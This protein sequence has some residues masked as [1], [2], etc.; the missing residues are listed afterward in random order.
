MKILVLTPGIY[1]D[2]HSGLPKLV[3][4]LA[5]ECARLGHGITILTRQYD[6]SHPQEEKRDGM[7]FL[8]I[9]IAHYG[10]AWH[11]LWPI[12]TAV[13]SWHGQRRLWRQNGAFELVWIHNPWWVS[14]GYPKRFWPAARVVYD[15]HS[16]ATSELVENHGNSLKTRLMGGLYDRLMTR[17][18]SRADKIIV[19]SQ[20]NRRKCLG[21]LGGKSRGV[22]LIPG[23][24]DPEL[25]HPADPSGKK[26]L[27]EEFGLPADKVVFV[28]AR[29]LRPRTGVDKLVEAASLL[30]QRGI[31]FY[32]VIIGNGV[33][34]NRIGELIRE[35][36]LGSH[37]KLVS[38][39]SESELADTYRAADVFVL[40]TQGAE[41][42]GLAT[43]EALSSGLV[44]LGTNNSATP[45]ILNRFNP[46]WLIEGCDAESIAS[47]MENY[48]GY[49]EKFSL[50]VETIRQRALE[51]YSWS[52]SA[53][54]FMEA[55][56]G[57]A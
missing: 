51:H 54:L 42:F 3:F 22:H 28:T 11:P 55:V 44:V 53:K 26:R 13:K 9:P 17:V 56:G 16:D 43:V 18:M 39:L 48:C 20:F 33:M 1:P 6:R 24:A 7:T 41:G 27:R 34:K 38:D 46:S 35:R 37:V 19:H 45:E 49:P 25:Y 21:L 12:E 2:R 52:V 5:R 30:L 10:T 8:R 23:A 36:Q 4:Y 40:P 57:N 14:L 32:L 15:F 31:S 50:P 47:A 29:G